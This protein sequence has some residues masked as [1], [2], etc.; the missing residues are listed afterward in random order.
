M[1]DNPVYGYGRDTAYEGCC[2]PGEGCDIFRSVTSLGQLYGI[3][4]NRDGKR[5]LCEFAFAPFIQS[6]DQEVP[7]LP[8]EPICTIGLLD[9]MQKTP[10]VSDE[11]LIYKAGGSLYDFIRAQCDHRLRLNPL[12][13]HE[14]KRHALDE[15]CQDEL[16]LQQR[17]AVADTGIRPVSAAICRSPV[18]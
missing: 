6:I 2:S 3:P 13:W 8:H 10:R 11:H 9:T 12:P 16:R 5:H 15:R 17:E 4:S 1:V 7:F 14:F 18:L